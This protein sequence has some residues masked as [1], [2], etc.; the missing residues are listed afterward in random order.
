MS[1]HGV[2]EKDAGKDGACRVLERDR[3]KG[4][5][6]G[7]K[8]RMAECCAFLNTGMAALRF[9]WYSVGVGTS[10]WY[11]VVD[12]TRPPLPTKQIRKNRRAF[13]VFIFV[14]VTKIKSLS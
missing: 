2:Q 12:V 7:W 10:C 5:T 14:S 1:C 13:L 8:G 4:K 11:S 6:A 3:L 9:D